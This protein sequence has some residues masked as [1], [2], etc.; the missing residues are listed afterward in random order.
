MSHE[1]LRREN[2]SLEPSAAHSRASAPTPALCTVPELYIY[3]AAAARRR[4]ISRS[5]DEDQLFVH[6]L[7]QSVF[8]NKS[9]STTIMFLLLR[10]EMTNA[11]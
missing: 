2:K 3:R 6:L 9:E 10:A 5:V 8:N 1:A 11:I 4:F 7:F